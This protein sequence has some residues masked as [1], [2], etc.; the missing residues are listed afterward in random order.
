MT[1]KT[2]DNNVTRRLFQTN[3]VLV[4]LIFLFLK[5]PDKKMLGVF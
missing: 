3:A 2:Y 1:M 5:N 4:V